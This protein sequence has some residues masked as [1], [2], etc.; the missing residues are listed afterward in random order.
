MRARLHRLPPAR[1][2]HIDT[3][4]EGSAPSRARLVCRT[5]DRWYDQAFYTQK[6]MVWHRISAPR[7]A[8]NRA[9]EHFVTGADFRTV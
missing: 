1:A 3:Q 5:L 4:H 6:S 2:R 9:I 7:P 8:M